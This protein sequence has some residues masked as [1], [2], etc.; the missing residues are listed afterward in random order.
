MTEQQDPQGSLE[1]TH[2]PYDGERLSERDESGRPKCPHCEFVDYGNPKACVAV[3]VQSR[4]R[5][6]LARR[7]IEPG[8]GLWD[9]P[10]GFIESGETAEQTV[11]REIKE[12]TDLELKDICYLMSIPDTYGDSGVPTLNLCFTAVPASEEFRAASDVTELKFLLPDEIPWDLLA[13]RHQKEVLETWKAGR[14]Q[15]CCD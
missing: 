5:V 10:G 12:E 15:Q 6:L 1:Y 8:R 2:C 4:G 9:I 14:A 13:F 7:G 11:A 3:L